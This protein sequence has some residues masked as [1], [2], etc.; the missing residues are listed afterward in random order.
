MAAFIHLIDDDEIF[1][2]IMEYTFR[3]YNITNFIIHNSAIEALEV[4][5]NDPPALILADINMP[6]MT[7]LEFLAKLQGIESLNQIP[8]LLMSSAIRLGEKQ[9]VENIEQ[10][11]EFFEK[12]LT[13]EN[14]M[15]IKDYMDSKNK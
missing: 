2:S 4:F 14:M 9:S 1:R 5:K 3:K 13:E 6:N 11:V 7:G 15:L 8:V 10:V 12:P